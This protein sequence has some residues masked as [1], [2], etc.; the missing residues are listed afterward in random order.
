MKD[1]EYLRN[2]LSEQEM[3]ILMSNVKHIYRFIKENRI[4]FEYYGMYERSYVFET[5][6]PH[7]SIIAAMAYRMKFILD[8]KLEVTPDKLF[9]E[10]IYHS[11]VLDKIAKKYYRLTLDI[12]KYSFRYNCNGD[13]RDTQ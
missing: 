5:K 9:V 3:G 12:I 11:G 13:T 8:R 10:P 6:T 4:I 1:T 2:V 7:P